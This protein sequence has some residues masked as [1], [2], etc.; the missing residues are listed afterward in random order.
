MTKFDVK[1][2]ISFGNRKIVLFFFFLFVLFFFF[3]LFIYLFIKIDKKIKMDQK[4]HAH[5]DNNGCF[6]IDRD[7]EVVEGAEK[8][9]TILD[10]NRRYYEDIPAHWPSE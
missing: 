2:I 6:Y 7:T 4:T 5:Y 10:I 3:N 1:M 9:E 8:G